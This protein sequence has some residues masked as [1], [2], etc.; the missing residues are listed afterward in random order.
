MKKSKYSAWLI[1]F[2]SIIIGLSV[3]GGVC[4]G[5]AFKEDFAFL[6][7]FSMIVVGV[8]VAFFLKVLSDILEYLQHITKQLDDLYRQN[9]L[10]KQH[11]DKSV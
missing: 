4:I 1:T 10:Q 6:F 8:F 2:S 3:I 9:E 7:A 5:I 11:F